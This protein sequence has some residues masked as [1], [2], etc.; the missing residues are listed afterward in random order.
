MNQTNDRGSGP[1]HRGRQRCR[2][3]AHMGRPNTDAPMLTEGSITLT[4]DEV[5]QRARRI[6]RALW[7]TSSQVRVIE[8]SVSMG[9]PVFGRP[10]CAEC[11]QRCR[12]RWSGPTPCH[13]SGSSDH[14]L[15]SALLGTMD[16]L[17]SLDHQ[18]TAS[19]G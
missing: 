2:H 18:Q 16:T 11:R 17:L 15:P 13:W 19:S 9:R 3:S 1:L 14:P 5:N 6:R 4:W 8:P 7:F 12:P 10:M